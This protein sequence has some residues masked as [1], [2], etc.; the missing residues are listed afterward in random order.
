MQKRE[1]SPSPWWGFMGAGGCRRQDQL[2]ANTDSQGWGVE[3]GTGYFVCGVTRAGLEAKT[4]TGQSC[5]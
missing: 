3:T 5:S 1:G 2:Q 4:S